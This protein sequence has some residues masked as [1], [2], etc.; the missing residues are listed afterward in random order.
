[1]MTKT[2]VMMKE[3]KKV[4]MSFCTPEKKAKKNHS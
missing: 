4:Q 3:M 2:T 1:M